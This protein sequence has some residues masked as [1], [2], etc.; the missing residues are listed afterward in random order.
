MA[1]P[2]PSGRWRA[3]PAPPPAVHVRRRR[4]QVPAGGGEHLHQQAGAQPA[5]PVHGR[6][7]L[8][9]LLRRQLPHDNRP[10]RV[11][12]L[13]SGVIVSEDGFI[14]TNHHVIEAADEIQVALPDGKTLEAEVVGTDPETDWRC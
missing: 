9:P 2:S 1:A 12:N 6:S 4:G 5:Q 3:R 14:L 11:S 8:P 10:Q 7:R 13:G